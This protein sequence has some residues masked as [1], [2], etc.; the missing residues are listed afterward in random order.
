[1]SGTREDTYA[2]TNDQDKDSTPCTSLRSLSKQGDNA[3]SDT[4]LSIDENYYTYSPLEMDVLH[5]L[6]LVSVEGLEA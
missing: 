6:K 5:L 1:M 3:S 4:S 2:Q